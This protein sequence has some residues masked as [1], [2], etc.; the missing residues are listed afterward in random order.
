MKILIDPE[1]PLQRFLTRYAQQV[2]GEDLKMYVRLPEWMQWD[3]LTGSLTLLP[4]EE[5]PEAVLED[6][7]L[8]KII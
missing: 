5:V 2:I 7:K 3:G 1:Q 8:D 4:A 6:L